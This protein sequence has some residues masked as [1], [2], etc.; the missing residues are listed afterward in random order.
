MAQD[1]F[2]S[3]IEEL[4]GSGKLSEVSWSSRGL[5]QVAMPQQQEHA[6]PAW[7]AACSEGQQEEAG[8]WCLTLSES[9]KH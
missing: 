9:V 6:R 4:F 1:Q 8:G 3:L 7:L 5:Q 2:I